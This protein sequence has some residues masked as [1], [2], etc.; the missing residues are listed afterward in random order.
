MAKVEKNVLENKKKDL[1]MYWGNSVSDLLDGK[2]GSG[3]LKAQYFPESLGSSRSAEYESTQIAFG[4]GDI[5]SWSS[6]SGVSIDG[7]TFSFS[8]DRDDDKLLWQDSYNYD[9]ELL[10]SIMYSFIVPEYNKGS[11]VALPPMVWFD[12]GIDLFGY[13]SL[14]ANDVNRDIINADYGIK[15]STLGVSRFYITSVSHTIESVFPGTDTIRAVT[16][17]IEVQESIYYDGK[18]RSSQFSDMYRR[19]IKR[20]K[21]NANRNIGKKRSNFLEFNF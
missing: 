19:N 21:N 7:L 1:I 13:G 17:E 18:I 10:I 15:N 3:F 9:I 16:F 4:V 11:I 14:N 12:F 6:A 2:S 8:R 20:L 5:L